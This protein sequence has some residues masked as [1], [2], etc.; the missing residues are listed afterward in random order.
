M[1]PKELEGYLP[2]PRK[3]VSV[4][5]RMQQMITAAEYG[6]PPHEWDMMPVK[7]RAE[8]LAYVEVKG[9]ISSYQMES[10]KEGG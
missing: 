9:L 7:S 8:M 2:K 3:P 1:I 10:D 5:W 4:N 6:I